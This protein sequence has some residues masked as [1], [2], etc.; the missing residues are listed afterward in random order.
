MTLINDLEK[1]SSLYEAGSLTAEEFAAAKQKLLSNTPSDIH[2]IADDAGEIKGSSEREF[3]GESNL[4]HYA[5]TGGA[6][7]E[8]TRLSRLE[9]RQ[10]IADLDRKWM[11]DRENYMISGRY[12]SR[13]VPTTWG[14]LFGGM[15][16]SIFGLFW[17]IIAS[18]IFNTRGGMAGH[19]R[20]HGVT[21]F[22]IFFP[23]LGVIFTIGGIALAIHKYSKAVAF[24][25]AE[26]TYQA[27]RAELE[28]KIARSSRN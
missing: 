11:I 3:V 12:G 1:L 17:T 28:R 8:I 25:Q 7:F 26:A 19:F 2:Y 5:F 24:Q 4:P 15:S 9:I 6:D 13:Y 23:L 21:P 18:S 14:S 20:G 10:E 22:A 16:V 27:R